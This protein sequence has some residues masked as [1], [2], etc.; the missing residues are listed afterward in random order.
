[1]ITMCL[2]RR[3]VGKELSRK[4]AMFMAA[5]ISAIPVIIGFTAKEQ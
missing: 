2:L 4:R 1:M 3:C 5:F